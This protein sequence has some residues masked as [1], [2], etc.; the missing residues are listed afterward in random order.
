[1]DEKYFK[2][3]IKEYI[4]YEIK[5]FIIDLNKYTKLLLCKKILKKKYKNLRK[6]CLDNN[7]R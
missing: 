7:E 4:K 5:F 2:K 6:R 3:F 1:M